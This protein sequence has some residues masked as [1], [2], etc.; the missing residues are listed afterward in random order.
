MKSLIHDKQQ[1]IGC[2]T[3]RSRGQQTVLLLRYNCSNWTWACE[4]GKA[5]EDSA[6]LLPFCTKEYCC[7]RKHTAV[8]EIINSFVLVSPWHL[9]FA[10]TTWAEYFLKS[11]QA[12]LLHEISLSV[13]QLK[14][15]TSYV[16]DPLWFCS[17]GGDAERLCEAQSGNLAALGVRECA[18]ERSQLWPSSALT[19]LLLGDSL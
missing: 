16:L 19:C 9:G 14:F 13:I 11:S 17:P 15:D 1:W 4:D 8:V 6:I 7:D 18:K 5:K 3:D 12:E 2:L 10:S